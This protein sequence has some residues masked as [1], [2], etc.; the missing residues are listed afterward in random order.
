MRDQE[1]C[2][3]AESPAIPWKAGPGNFRNASSALID[4]KKE[5]NF[6]ETRVIEYQTSRALSWD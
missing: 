6:F 5:E 4:L 2:L 3:A 1:G